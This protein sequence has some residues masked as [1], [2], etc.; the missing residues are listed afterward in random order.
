MQKEFWQQ[1]WQSNQIGFHLDQAHPLLQK[2]H[3]QTF[4]ETTSVFVPLCGK[5]KD[6]IYLCN[7]QY[8]VIGNELSRTAVYDFYQ[9]NFDISPQQLAELLPIESE[10]VDNDKPV[11][12]EYAESRIYLGDFFQLNETDLCNVTGIYDR[13]ALVA[14]PKEMRKDYVS[15]LKKLLPKATLLLITLEYEQALMSGPPFS[16]TESEVNQLF[17]FAKIVNLSRKD[18]IEKEPRFK[19]K[20]LTYFIESV[21]QISW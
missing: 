8:Q 6:L 11:A 10:K 1:K 12:I 15:H 13:A 20:G 18:I 2:F 5:T 9:E 17:S 16:V 3:Q 14:L 21:Y 19:S 7:N 4:A